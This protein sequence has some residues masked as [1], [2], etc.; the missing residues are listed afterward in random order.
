MIS[1]SAPS[2]TATWQDPGV[3]T[4]LTDTDILNRSMLALM[5]RLL[6]DKQSLLGDLPEASY[7]MTLALVNRLMRELLAVDDAQINVVTKAH[8]T[9]YKPSPASRARASIVERLRLASPTP[10]PPRPRLG[11]A[12]P[13]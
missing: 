3:I 9:A 13:S 8:P 4:P 11:A 12:T 5:R 2:L 1:P 10:S 7:C 6:H